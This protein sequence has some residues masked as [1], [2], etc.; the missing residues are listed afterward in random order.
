M[1]RVRAVSGLTCLP[2]PCSRAEVA[3]QASEK[4][5][6]MK[7]ELTDAARSKQQ[8]QGLPPRGSSVTGTHVHIDLCRV[9]RALAWL[10][11]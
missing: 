1:M 11:K 5:R 10:E 4:T 3:P 9:L 7:R 2:G 6:L 8:Q